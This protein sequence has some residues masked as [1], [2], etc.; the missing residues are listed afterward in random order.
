[1]LVTKKEK[2]TQNNQALVSLEIK[3]IQTNE[4]TIPIAMKFVKSGPV[5]QYTVGNAE[6]VTLPT[7]K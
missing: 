2:K 5:R 4:K 6:S 3:C 7:W 1:M